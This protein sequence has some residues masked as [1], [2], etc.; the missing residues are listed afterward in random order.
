MLWPMMPGR[1]EGVGSWRGLCP[2]E[3]D[4]AR[5]MVHDEPG[6]VAEALGPEAG[7]IAVADHDEQVGPLGRF[8]DLTLD[9]PMPYLCRAGHG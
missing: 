6:C 3:E 8:H 7:P 9:P 1:R 5:G 2:D 4:R